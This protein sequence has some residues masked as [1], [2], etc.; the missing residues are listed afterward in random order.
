VS[1][2][3]ETIAAKERTEP[4][5]RAGKLD[6][7][8]VVSLS[9]SVG[10]RRPGRDTKEPRRNTIWW[11]AGACAIALVVLGIFLSIMGPPD[12]RKSVRS[13]T[14]T[15]QRLPFASVLHEL[16]TIEALSETTVLTRFAG[17]I[18]WK[19]EDGK[20]VEAGEPIV[21]F[22]V[23][24]AQED[25]WQREKDLLDK[26]D[27]V[28][29]AEQDIVVTTE[30]YRHLIRQAE[31]TQGLAEIERKRIYED[32]TEQDRL[33]A[34]LTWKSA[35]LESD[36][37]ELEMKGYDDLAV[38]GFVSE[39][40]RKKK[41]LELA[42]IR[43]NLSKAKLIYDL[44][45]QGYTPDSKR[46]ADLAVADAR[47]RTNISTFN[48]DADL[49]VNRATLDLARVD[50][51]NFERELDRKK[52][53]F[54]AA[55]VRAPIK[56]NVVF[57]EVMKGS[58]KIKAP[59]QVGE[60]RTAGADLC[61][62]CDTSS[63]RVRVWVNE[64]DVKGV[65]LN[66]PANITLPACPGQTLQAVVSEIAVM[67]QDKNAALSSLALRKSGEAFVNVVPVKL[68]FINLTEEQRRLIRVGFT[69][70]VYIQTTE[71][72]Q[73]L[74]VPWAAIRYNEKT[75]PFADVQAGSGRERRALKLGRN[76]SE[77]VEVLEGLKEGEQV[78]DQTQA[79]K[80]AGARS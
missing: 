17:D 30:R 29:R 49:A 22:E 4:V 15:V 75:Q 76:D 7:A 21:R 36:K 77:R 70:H 63:L 34:E 42:T 18:V 19:T 69:A 11:I 61:T 79:S 37:A 56:G 31:I 65:A 71:R 54:E 52:R 9:V 53:D 55:T 39:A 72:S 3:R 51:V 50:L 58:L 16:G 1:D 38:Q 33:D 5:L 32:P 2:A 14:M 74:T 12:E 57:T 25:L 44:T 28:R 41:Q 59:I 47:K 8:P 24:T 45:L 48:R 26:R 62:I 46:V 6:G 10:E 67:A 64:A 35:T 66:Q 20:A 78:H 13:L 73:A 80:P 60:S 27:A 68:D 40:A 43:V 23:K